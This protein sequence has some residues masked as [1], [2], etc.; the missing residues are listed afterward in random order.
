MH[1]GGCAGRIVGL[2]SFSAL[3]PRVACSFL[4][5]LPLLTPNAFGNGE[6]ASGARPNIIFVLVDDMGWGD[7]NCNWNYAEKFKN[8]S[9][10]NRFKTPTLDKMASEGILLARHYTA[11][12]VSAPARA[13]LMTGMHQGHTRQVRDNTFDTP[14]A[15]VH[16]LG[17]VLSE[18]GYATAAIGKWGIGGVGNGSNA[19]R[20]YAR[21]R[22]RG[23]DYFYGIFDHLAGH[24]H[25]P[26]NC[27][28]YVWENETNVTPKLKNG[29]AYSTDL[30]TARAKDWI[31]KSKKAKPNQPFFLYLALPA[32]HGSLRVPNCAYPA[33]GGLKGGVQWTKNGTVNTASPK[34]GEPDSYIH[35]DNK[36]FAT[37]AA[38]RHSTMIRRVDDAMADLFKLLKDL[39]I[40]DNTMVVF[41]SDNGPHEEP[42]NDS[43]RTAYFSSGSPAQDPAFFKSYG[44]MDG[45]K[46]DVFEGGLRVPAIVRW[47][48]FIPKKKMT[49]EPSQFHDWLA[50]FAD[51]AGAEIPSSSDGVSIL[52]TLTGSGEQMPGQIYC[53]YSV[54]GSSTHRGDFV[55]AH[56]GLSRRNQ[57][58]VWVDGY[59]GLARNLNE[60][61]KFSGDGAVVFEIYDTLK[62]P[63]ETKNLAGK[64]GFGEDFQQ[65]LR[66]KAL[67]SRRAFDGKH[68]HEYTRGLD[69]SQKVFFEKNPVPAIAKAGNSAQLKFG[70]KAF[71]SDKAFP[72]VPDFRQTHLEPVLSGKDEKP[73]GKNLLPQKFIDGR[74]ARGILIEGTISVPEEGEYVFSLKT[75]KNKGSKAFVHLYDIQLIDAD[76]LYKPGTEAK[77]YANVGTEN[78]TG[79]RGVRL[80]A[81]THKIRI[82]YVCAANAKNPSVEISFKKK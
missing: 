36:N 79:T 1:V 78:A 57:L 51:A 50:T 17:S 71:A 31:V 65:K 10:E 41:T 8:R 32:P 9:R 45:I 82:E 27:G 52:P 26:A 72:W 38:R 30:F 40:D 49:T 63:Q 23:F 39:K 37:D 64:P 70:Y 28:R 5:T 22:E 54:G 46:R 18:A 67:R 77:S 47:P 61:T 55:P 35:P 13:S 15:D 69:F 62:D 7:L 19:D 73:L 66:D 56:R 76:K 43:A 20:G 58:V 75:D 12:P 53:E 80:A 60:N 68:P 25:Y 29:N 33:G 59:K 81:G 16:T 34:L 11:C 24:Y 3:L 4:T 74:G 2:M 44:M 14:I 48:K 21:A 6:S 42:G